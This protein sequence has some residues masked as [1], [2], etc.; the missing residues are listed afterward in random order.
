MA[1]ERFA[2]ANEITLA[3][4][5]PTRFDNQQEYDHTI[6]RLKMEFPEKSSAY[7]PS[8]ELPGLASALMFVG[9]FLGGP[10]GLIAAFIV[11][12]IG[13]IVILLLLAL[14]KIPIVGWL[15]LLLMIPI[16]LAVFVLQFIA[17]GAVV[18][19]VVAGMGKLGKNRSAMAPM[20][21]SVGSVALTEILFSFVTFSMLSEMN[22]PGG[23]EIPAVIWIARCAI[24]VAIAGFTAAAVA[25]EFVCSSKF[26]EHCEM[27]MDSTMLSEVTI[28]GLRA[29]V[30]SMDG[31]NTEVM[32]GVYCT[33]IGKDGI[34]ELHYCPKCH[35]GF[36]DLSVNING[37]YKDGAGDE[38]EACETWLVHSRELAPMEVMQLRSLTK[39]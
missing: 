27:F 21:L 35:S 7:V 26:C 30:K 3:E 25:K 15:A 24:G 37:A 28:G 38:Q 14:S 11:E 4:E 1:A 13:L 32:A 10:A 31:R 12:A 17:A 36:L 9:F 34:S 2:A 33:A 5:C 39:R 8:G 6:N 19:F 29:L 22:L 18:A 16:G 23:I 20:V